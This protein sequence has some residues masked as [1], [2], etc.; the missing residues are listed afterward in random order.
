M[1][2]YGLKNCDTCRKAL[3]ALPQAELVDVAS[4]AVPEAVLDRALAQFG[5]RMVN[6][7]STTWRSLSDAER[8][9]GP[10]PL[11]VAHP[12]LMKRPLIAD[13]DRLFLGWDAET[14]AALV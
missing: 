5:D 9:A 11:L 6:T 3:R 13:G 10:K 4:T 8:A 7:R 14:R 1:K 2:L 12:K